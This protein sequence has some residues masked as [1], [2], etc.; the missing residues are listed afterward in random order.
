MRV[1]KK[2]LRRG[3]AQLPINYPAPTVEDSFNYEREK[4]R[5]ENLC[6]RL[7][8]NEVEIRDAVLAEIPRFLKELTQ[9]LVAQQERTGT[10]DSADVARAELIMMKLCVGLHYCF[11]HSDKPLVQHECAFKISQ[12][13]FAPV[14]NS[15]RVMFIRSFFKILTREWPKIDHYRIDKYMALVRKVM[16]QMIALV[17]QIERGEILPRPVVM[18]A[19]GNFISAILDSNQGGVD[20]KKGKKTTSVAKQRAQ[21]NG[22][23][24]ALGNVL[25]ELK[26]LFQ[27]EVLENIRSVGLT[28]HICDLMF[29]ELTRAKLS[30]DLFVQLASIIP[31]F[32]MSRGNYVEKR[33]LDNF[34]APLTGGVIESQWENDDREQDILTLYSRMVDVCRE[35]SVS[36]RTLRNVRMMFSEA[37]LLL[38][39][40]LV[41]LGAPNELI[42]TRPADLRRTIEREVKEIDAM[43]MRVAREKDGIKQLKR[44]ERTKAVRTVKKAVASGREVDPK[45]AAVAKAVE[46]R[47]KK[48]SLV[49]DTKRKKNYKLTKKDLT[50]SRSFRIAKK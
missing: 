46:A 31:C 32:A 18:K 23:V 5:V 14:S 25:A 34:F 27:D 43:R 44:T 39:Q 30:V 10:V 36:N 48:K 2:D 40:R 35:Y 17:S 15:Y 45:M 20:S 21:A 47:A 16:F 26:T 13:L 42:A 22:D 12:L 19:E 38:E 4:D 28:M 3:E 41:S 6:K 33:V 49:R 9:P 8:N 37:Q 1:K 50:E 11:W 7:A 24:N 29:D